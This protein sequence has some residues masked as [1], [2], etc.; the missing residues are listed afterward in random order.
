MKPVLPCCS[1]TDW[2]PEK[3]V[4]VPKVKSSR[5][6]DGWICETLRVHRH[7]LSVGGILLR[8]FGSSRGSAINGR[9]DEGAK[10]AAVAT[11]R[12]EV[13][14]YC[15][16]WN[17]ATQLMD[18]ASCGATTGP[19]H[20]IDSHDLTLLVLG[21]QFTIRFFNNDTN[22]FIILILLISEMFHFLLD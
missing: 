19:A 6:G 10:D 15:K 7:H 22:G 18:T 12:A 13:D 14:C 16:L 9:N 17:E 8:S 20:I 5:G 11:G 2:P 21:H 3:S 1:Q 4:S